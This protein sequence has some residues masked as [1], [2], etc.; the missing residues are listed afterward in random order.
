MK[1]QSL[2]ASAVINFAEKLEDDSSK[3]YQELADR[4][5]Q[6]QTS[7]L[8]FATESQNNKILLVRTYRETITD[9]MEACFSFKGLKLNRSEIRGMSEKN[10]TYAGALK[11][12]VELETT[13]TE[14][15]FN[16]LKCSKELLATISQSFGKV[17]QRRKKRMLELELMLKN[18]G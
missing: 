17:G 2:T 9:A 11:I 13:A 10:I 7:F 18:N 1:E 14:F 15:Y 8:S 12:A 5:P 16:A 4:Y 6:N 3:F